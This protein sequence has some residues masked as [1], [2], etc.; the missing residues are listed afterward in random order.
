MIDLD[1]EEIV[2][3]IKIKDLNAKVFAKKTIVALVIKIDG[4]DIHIKMTLINQDIKVLFW[5]VIL[6]FEI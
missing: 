6:E 1:A 3:V 5:I 2:S 4:H